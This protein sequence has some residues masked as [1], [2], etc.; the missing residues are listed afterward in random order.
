MV[1]TAIRLPADLLVRPVTSWIYDRVIGGLSRATKRSAT[2]QEIALGTVSD[3]G[4]PEPYIDARDD[5]DSRVNDLLKKSKD[6][7]DQIASLDRTQARVAYL[8]MQES[9]DSSL[10]NMLLAQ[11]PADSVATLDAMKGLIDQMGREAVKLGLLS[12][13]SYDRNKLAYLHRTYAKHELTDPNAVRIAANRKSIRGD[14]FKGRGLRDDIPYKPD[15]KRGDKFRRLELRDPPKAE[16]ER[17]KLK[18]RVYLPA[19]QAVPAAYA[20]WIDDG[21]WEARFEDRD[22]KWGLWRDMNAQE[23]FA[24]GEIE[25]VRYAFAR[26]MLSSVQDI[27]TAK[28]LGWTANQY[29]LKNEEAV[30]AAGGFVSDPEKT[31]DGR[32]SI[33][34]YAD[35]EYVLVPETKVKGT[36]LNKYGALAGTYIPGALW[37]D[38]RQ[39]VN[40]TADSWYGR[41]WDDLLRAWKISKTAL[42]PAVHTNNIMSNFIMADIADVSASDMVRALRTILDSQKGDAKARAIFDRFGASGAE[43]GSFMSVEL[44]KDVIEPLLRQLEMEQDNAMAGVGIIQALRLGT[45]TSMKMR[46]AW[47]A[48]TSKQGTKEAA[49]PFELL[50]EAYR[51]ED[52][53]FRLAKWLHETDKGMDDRAAGKL[54]KSAFLDY[55]VNAPWIQALRRGPLPFVAFTYRIIPLLAQTAAH[56]PWKLMKY[57]AV[58]AGLNSLAYAMLGAAGFD[59]DEEEERR[60][61]PEEKSG[62]ALGVFPRLVRMPWNDDNNSPVFLDVRRWIPGGDLFDV[63]GSQSAIPAPSW[64][65][66][67]GPL[68]LMVEL[69]SNKSQFTGKPIW[70]AGDSDAQKIERTMDHLFKFMAPNLPIPNPAALLGLNDR[71]LQ[72]YSWSSISEVGTGKT[73]AFGR[74]LSM[75]QALSSAVGVK[76]ASYPR[77][78]M[79][80][81]QAFKRDAEIRIINERASQLRRQLNTNTL[82]MEEFT[83]K[84]ADIRERQ[85]RVREKF[86]E[87]VGAGNE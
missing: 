60:L 63:E 29:G 24:I 79:L 6:L 5:R 72:T 62:R 19:G 48:F 32:N 39:T 78:V 85:A 42:S 26:T 80:R 82:T 45:T 59:A 11:L 84:M 51:S 14:S 21:I 25:E 74:E 61:L 76:L 46:M 69:F 35:N 38:I 36:K 73:D 2:L 30:T 9:P 64:L 12:Q 67:G 44:R 22:D 41:L 87:I 18:R 3:Y 49:A 81:Q 10:E 37:N 1:E 4:L 75:P 34:V 58:G 53:V 57:L 56:K 20:G 40:L 66:V 43:G 33:Q 7:I 65:S 31:K 47:S 27:E 86:S 52:T 13:D 68:A 77:D 55:N 15:I 28:F 8:W 83:E 23:R 50:I 54:A 71:M 16:G 17:G 70:T